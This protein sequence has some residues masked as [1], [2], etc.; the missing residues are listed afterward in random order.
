LLIRFT[1]P[2][3]PI[4]PAQTPKTEVKIKNQKGI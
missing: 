4:F 1:V 3:P 2:L